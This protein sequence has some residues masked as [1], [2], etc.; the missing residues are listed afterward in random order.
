M[1]QL[2]QRFTYAIVLGSCLM[3]VFCCGIPL[4]LALTNIAAMFGIAG[5]GTL[6]S[7]WFEQ[8]EVTVLV[9][10]G[11]MLALTGLI[12][13]VSNRINCRTDGHCSHE[14]C[15]KKKTLSQH[16]FT[17]AVLLFALNVL[18]FFASH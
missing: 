3:H 16:M 13:L 11:G 5:A 9:L 17:F 12:Q 6:H 4:L 1:Q 15:D 18:L 10:A 7:H 2:T 14:P 8:F